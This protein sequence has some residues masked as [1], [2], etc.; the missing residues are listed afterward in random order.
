[1]TS[2]ILKKLSD[3]VLNNQIGLLGVNSRQS[4]CKK[5]SN[6]KKTP[7]ADYLYSSLQKHKP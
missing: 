1:M 3:S 5:V 4:L 7:F 2:I 6:I